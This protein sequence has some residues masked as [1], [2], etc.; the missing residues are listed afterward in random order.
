MRFPPLML[1]RAVGGTA[2]VI[3]L[4]LLAFTISAPIRRNADGATRADEIVRCTV[5]IVKPSHSFVSYRRLTT[6]LIT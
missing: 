2:L 4:I 5:P 1:E 6:I 3:I